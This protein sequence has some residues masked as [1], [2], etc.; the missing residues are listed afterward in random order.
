MPSVDTAVELSLLHSVAHW[1]DTISAAIRKLFVPRTEKSIISGNKRGKVH[2]ENA[3]SDDQSKK[4]RK[5]SGCLDDASKQLSMLMFLYDQQ[6]LTTT[7]VGLRFSNLFACIYKSQ[8]K[9]GMSSY[10]RN[11]KEPSLPQGPGLSS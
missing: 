1:F 2:M 4:L 6:I 9:D 11:L 3:K 7:I 8:R 5:L 10:R